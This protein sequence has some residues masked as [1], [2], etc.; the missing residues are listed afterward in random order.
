MKKKKK[1][2][3]NINPNLGGPFRGPFQVE[4]GGGAKLP[5]LSKTC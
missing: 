4:E 5:P 1:K 2:N 3:R